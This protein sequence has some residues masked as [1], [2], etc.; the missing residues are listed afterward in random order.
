MDFPSFVAE[1]LS[2]SEAGSKQERRALARKAFQSLD[3][4]TIRFT[5]TLLRL[6]EKE[7]SSPK[8]MMRKPFVQYCY[9][10]TG[11]VCKVSRYRGMHIVGKGSS[12]SNIYPVGGL[13]PD[14][15]LGEISHSS[16]G[17]EP[18]SSF[19]QDL[20]PGHPGGDVQFAAIIPDSVSASSSSLRGFLCLRWR[21]L[22]S[23]EKITN[24]YYEKIIQTPYE[25]VPG[26]I[27]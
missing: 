4:H 21:E 20:V 25:V 24:L 3:K 10:Q 19:W 5:Q 14:H 13:N 7:Q 8:V 9:L 2:Y 22:E 18:P 17:S 26:L 12:G 11:L 6:V 23:E 16:V 27:H 15:R 1:S